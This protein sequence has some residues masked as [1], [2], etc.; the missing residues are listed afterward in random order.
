ML[1]VE[2]ILTLLAGGLFVAVA[3]SVL[4]VLWIRITQ[5]KS[6]DRDQAVFLIKLFCSIG[7]LPLVLGILM[8]LL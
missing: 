1:D 6:F 2:T 3:G 7:L 8:K 4:S 5:S